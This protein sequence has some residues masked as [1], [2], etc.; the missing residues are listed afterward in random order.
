MFIFISNTLKSVVGIK[1][2]KTVC[3]YFLREIVLPV[4]K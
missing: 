1:P 2:T 4:C 3:G